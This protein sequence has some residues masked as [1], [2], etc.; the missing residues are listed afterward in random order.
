MP[1]PGMMLPRIA[2][3]P[4]PMYTTSGLLSLTATAPTDALVICPSV[5]GAQFSPP[6]VVFQ[7][8][9]PVA[10]KYAS[11]RRPTTP[12]AAIDRPPRSGPMFRHRNDLSNVESSVTGANWAAR[13][14]A[15]AGLAGGC[16]SA[17][18]TDSAERNR[19]GRSGSM[20]GNEEAVHAGRPHADGPPT[21]QATPRLGNSLTRP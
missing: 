2:D 20:V 21:L 13:T 19:K 10:P 11:F 17:A 4:I 18:G 3:S 12:L 16:R 15:A 7:S 1:S 14:V 8:P 6:S 9:P 5:T